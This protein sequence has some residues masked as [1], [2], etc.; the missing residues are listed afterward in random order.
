M[1]HRFET[2]AIHA[3]QEPEPAYG[4]VCTPVYMTSTFVQSAP[5]VHKG[6]D[7][8]RADNPTRTAL[9]TNLAA[10]EDAR[11]GICFSSGCAATAAVIHWLGQDAHIISMDDV[12]GGTRRLFS[13][14]FAHAARSF[15]FVDLT[16]LDK[17]E[18][19]IKPNTKAVWIET[20]TNPLLKLVDIAAVVERAKAHGLIVIVDNTFMSP[21]FQS[22]LALGADVV[23]H[24]CTKYLGGHSDVV[25]GV[26]MT[27]DDEAAERLHF[28]Q[29]SV[30][31]TPGPMDCFL[32]LRGTK[33]LA[34]RMRQHDENGRKVAQW[35][36]SHPK[37]ERVIYPGLPSHPQHELANRQMSGCGGM[38]SFVV[39]GGLP[40][41][42]RFLEHCKVFTLA[43]SLGGVES[44][45]E[46]PAIMTHASVPAE[47]RKELGID[48]GLIRISTGIE[49]IDDLIADLEQ[50]LDA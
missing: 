19:H 44:L 49:H 6:Y 24:S 32:V 39:K 46:H 33:T 13:Q 23:V 22:P 11:H 45:I 47:I 14:V 18:A 3:G 21:Y 29:K 27:N 26:V 12:Y 7:Y 41:A 38:M 20:P 40:A 31:A 36:E 16:D 35:L 28:V 8:S 25:M 17:L 2:R 5:G 50:A 42:S 43:E 4:A 10:L 34:I 15:D 48:D 9:E 30:G 37:V 1:S